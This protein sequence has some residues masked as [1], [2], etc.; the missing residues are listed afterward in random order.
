TDGQQEISAQRFPPM[1]C[2]LLLT[3]KRECELIWSVHPAVGERVD[4]QQAIAELVTACQSKVRVSELAPERVEEIE[5]RAEEPEAGNSKGTQKIPDANAGA[6][7]ADAELNTIW[8]A[9]LNTKPARATDDFFDLGGH[10]LLAAR[11]M[12]R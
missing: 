3:Q 6:D 8:E 5:Q 11:L 7:T 1:R 9:V 12:A 2:A 4:V 10:S